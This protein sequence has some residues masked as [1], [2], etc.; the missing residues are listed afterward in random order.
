MIFVIF[1]IM[2][3][4]CK[5][6]D[7]TKDEVDFN[8]HSSGSK[9]RRGYCK[10]CEKEKNRIRRMSEEYKSRVRSYTTKEE[11]IKRLKKW[12]EEN[13][14][15]SEESRKKWV[16]NN[17]EK[18]KQ[19]RKNYKKNNPE[20]VKQYRENYKKNNPE[21]YKLSKNVRNRIKKYMKIKNITKDNKTF[22]IVGCTPEK[23]KEHI[24]SQFTEGMSWDNYGFYGW[25]IDHITP[26]SSAKTKEGLYE[27]CH[28]SNLQPLWMKDNLSKGS[29]LL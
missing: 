5:V 1:I 24:E 21:K 22:D 28:F 4:V 9:Y 26:L 18:V 20:K 3:K 16:K 25:H 27:L 12:N 8:L 13:P 2:K 23:L 29:S 7:I 15:K 17:L 14:G 19:Y 11:K 6:C 10:E